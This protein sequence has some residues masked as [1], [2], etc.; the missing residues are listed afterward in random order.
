MPS[1]DQEC[2][3]MNLAWAREQAITAVSVAS[4][5]APAVMSGTRPLLATVASGACYGT[6]VN[7]FTSIL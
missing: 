3:G 5:S 7:R 1:E 6:L 2:D 4:S